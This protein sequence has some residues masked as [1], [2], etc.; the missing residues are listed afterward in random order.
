[1][2]G[3]TFSQDNPLSFFT[4]ET[5]ELDSNNFDDLVSYNQKVPAKDITCFATVDRFDILQQIALAK[6]ATLGESIDY[7]SGELVQKDVHSISENEKD[8]LEI[9]KDIAGP[10][11]VKLDSNV[12]HANAMIENEQTKIEDDLTQ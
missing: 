8:D 12:T 3:G 1:M 11:P 7:F 9:T 4:K 2:H 10:E 6:G 5:I